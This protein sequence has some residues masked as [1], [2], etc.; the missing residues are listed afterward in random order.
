MSIEKFKEYYNE[1]KNRISIKMNEFN[2][3]LINEYNI[4]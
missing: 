4:P 3:Q 1:E 2:N